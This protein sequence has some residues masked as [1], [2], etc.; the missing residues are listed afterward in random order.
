MK[1][2]K[3]LDLLKKLVN[4]KTR[5]NHRICEVHFEKKYV[6]KSTVSEGRKFLSKDA[7]PT[8][9]LERIPSP[10][11]LIIPGSIESFQKP[12]NSRQITMINN[13]YEAEY[14]NLSSPLPCAD[15]AEFCESVIK[16]S[17]GTQT[18]AENNRRKCEDNPENTIKKIKTE[19]CI[20]DPKE[21]FLR[22]C[23]QYL[24]NSMTQIVKWHLDKSNNCSL[25]L[26][27]LNLYFSGNNY[28]LLSNIL[29][30]P[31][32]RTL[33]HF[34]IPKNTELST[35]FVNA[36]K[37]KVNNMSQKG[38]ICSFSVGCI[39]LKPHLYY[40]I[41]FDRIIGFHDMDG[42]QITTPAKYAVMLMLQGILEKW[43]QP[44]TYTFISEYDNFPE[45]SLWIDEVL[46]T[47]INIGLDIR[48]FISDPRSEFLYI[49]ES[50]LVTPEKPYFT[51][52]GKNIYYIYDALQLL[53]IVKNN[54]KSC[55]FHYNGQSADGNASADDFFKK[56]DKLYNILN[57]KTITS[58]SQFSRAFTNDKIQTDYM[59]QML[60]LF[61]HLKVLRKVD[62]TDVTENMKFIKCF[63]ISIRSVL[64]LFNEL[65]VS[66]ARYLLTSRLTLS[67]LEK[68]FKRVKQKNSK[69]E[70]TPR[71]F[72]RFFKRNLVIS[73]MKKPLKCNP[74]AGMGE[75]NPESIMKKMH[76]EDAES[77]L[78]TPLAV[79]TTDYRIG[80]PE[81]N[82]FVY[83]CGY[84]YLKCIQK[85]H[86]DTLT[87][88]LKNVESKSHDK[89]SLTYRCSVSLDLKSRNILPPDSFIKFLMLLENK[90]KNYF[91]PDVQVNSVGQE[92]F[93]EMENSTFDIPCP[94]FP[95]DYL[96]MLFI[97]VRIFYMIRKNNKAFRKK[98]R[99]KL[100]R[101]YCL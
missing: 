59:K 15:I 81:K 98:R 60:N 64:Q 38:K 49:S 57:S 78:N 84:C 88:Y 16:V 91:K 62:G 9:N 65:V 42:E 8:L 3:R 13:E 96:K 61:K 37:S 79:A 99:A 67:Y 30:L 11:S 25:N 46:A 90:F 55:N 86:C 72:N 22:S 101:V 82:A 70:C 20:Q 68:L 51:V 18:A 32:V 4:E 69:N 19:N 2:V 54:F 76:Y 12:H 56:L 93:K 27:A 28:N 6:Q 21:S 52:N 80:L 5:G 24:P 73:L 44:V 17:K 1:A 36:L 39:L 85:H 7:F 63:Q 66:G 47:L 48:A 35:H 58:D 31:T 83:V 53:K 97:R 26:F 77:N 87:S 74:N 71:Q 100:F 95:I 43:T 40:D 89:N 29:G 34:L 23:Y 41:Q 92:I 50:R 75:E 14:E 10:C 94:C 45:I 33:K